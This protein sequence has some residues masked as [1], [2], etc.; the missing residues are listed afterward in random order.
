MA[1]LVLQSCFAFFSGVYRMLVLP[2]HYLAWL[3]SPLLLRWAMSAIG[4]LLA[5]QS[6]FRWVMDGKTLGPKARSF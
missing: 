1:T 4:L 2:G 3:L 5:D 6:L